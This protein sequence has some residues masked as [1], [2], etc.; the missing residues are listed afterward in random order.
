MNFNEASVIRTK[1]RGNR[2]MMMRPKRQMRAHL[3]LF[4]YYRNDIGRRGGRWRDETAMRWRHT[5][6]EAAEAVM[7]I[8]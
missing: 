1:R 5:D 2:E 6:A 8:F 4:E 3:C 7:R